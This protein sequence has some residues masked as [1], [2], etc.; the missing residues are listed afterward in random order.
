MLYFLL[1]SALFNSPLEVLLQKRKNIAIAKPVMP[2][3]P[4]FTTSHTQT[5]EDRRH[6][7]PHATDLGSFPLRFAGVFPGM[8]VK[9]RS[10]RVCV[11]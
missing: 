8:A 5:A 10:E 11:A 9:K 6:T 2:L 4:H 1:F 3:A 7:H